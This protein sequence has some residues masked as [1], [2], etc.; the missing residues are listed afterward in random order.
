MRRWRRVVLAVVVG[1]ALLTAADAVLTGM[2]GDVPVVM[3]ALSIMGL[4][5]V[6]L[7]QMRSV[8][9]GEVRCRKL[10]VDEHGR[11]RAALAMRDDEPF[12]A[13]KDGQ[14]EFHALLSVGEGRSAL[15]LYDRQGG[16]VRL[17]ASKGAS[18]L[19][20][21]DEN[22]EIWSVARNGGT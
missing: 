8:S 20:L 17:C 2:R 7:A 18:E 6:V 1:L 21:V 15:A 13:L 12:L 9:V 19:S 4:A 16:D 14:D 5:A 11:F 10:V 3:L 22:G